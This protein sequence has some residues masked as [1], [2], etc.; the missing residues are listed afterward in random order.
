MSSRNSRLETHQGSKHVEQR[1]GQ[2]SAWLTEPQKASQTVIMHVT[3]TSNAVHAAA[4][5]VSCMFCRLAF[6]TVK[7][8]ECREGIAVFQHRSRVLCSPAATCLYSYT[9]SA[10]HTRSKTPRNQS[11]HAQSQCATLLIAQRCVVMRSVLS[12]KSTEN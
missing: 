6:M 9:L 4:V 12:R 2:H 3:R 1:Y 5:V 10:P 8:Y 11:Q 7:R